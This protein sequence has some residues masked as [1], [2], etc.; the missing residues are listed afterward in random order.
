ML[1]NKLSMHNIEREKVL[2]TIKKDD[3]C[4]TFHELM[5]DGYF[6]K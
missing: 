3:L 1:S 5:I 2:K 6:G 4:E